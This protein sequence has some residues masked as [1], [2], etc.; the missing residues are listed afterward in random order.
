MNNALNNMTDN[1]LPHHDHPYHLVA[2]SPWPLLVSLAALLFFGGFTYFLHGAH[3]RVTAL[4][5]TAILLIVIAALWWKDVIK[6][7]LQDRAHNKT[8]RTGLKLGMILFIFSEFAI[9]VVFF[10]SFVRYWTMESQVMPVDELWTMTKA[11]W[12][13]AD[14]EIANPW[15]IPLLN[16]FILL[17]SGTTTTWAHSSIIKNDKKNASIA[18]GCTIALGALFLCLQIAE[19][20][21]LNFTLKQEGLA[22][23]YTTNFFIITGFHGF[24]VLIGVLFLSICQLRMKKITPENHLSFEFAAWYWHFVDIIW[25]LLFVLLYVLSR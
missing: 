20:M 1:A 22:A 2:P 15:H 24:H 10:A 12:P 8:V 13:P 17:L 21:H 5:G 19:Y 25:I 9:F 7:A 23:I 14:L 11:I 4:L 3:F 6:E 18:N 16:T